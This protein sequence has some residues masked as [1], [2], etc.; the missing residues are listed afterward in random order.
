MADSGFDLGFGGDPVEFAAS[1]LVGAAE[2]LGELLS[3]SVRG[4]EASTKAGRDAL[5]QVF[6]SPIAGLRSEVDDVRVEVSPIT[7]LAEPEDS[8]PPPPGPDPCDA[9]DGSV[10]IDGISRVDHSVEGC[11]TPLGE[12]PTDDPTDPDRPTQDPDSPEPPSDPPTDD[13][14]NCCCCP[15]KCDDDDPEPPDEPEDDDK[16]CLWVKAETCEYVVLSVDQGDTPPDLGFVRKSCCPTFDECSDRGEEWKRRCEK[17]EPPTVPT[18]GGAEADD[19]CNP[20]LVDNSSA[21]LAN[22][23]KSLGLDRDVNV[24]KVLKEGGGSWFRSIASLLGIR[25]P[26]G[27]NYDPVDSFINDLIGRVFGAT[28]AAKATFGCES[29]EYSRITALNSIFSLIQKYTITLPAKIQAEMSYAENYLCPWNLPTTD[30][31]D[32]AL[33]GNTITE[34]TH[35]NL[36]K[37]NGDCPDLH[38]AVLDAKRRKLSPL[39]SVALARRGFWSA[40][41]AEDEIRAQGFVRP[42]SGAAFDEL[43]RFLAS[44]SD[45]I[46]LMQRDVFDE[47]TV[48]RFQLDGIES[49]GSAFEQKYTGAAARRGDAVGLDSETARLFWRAHWELPSEIRLREFL[50][51]FREI[52]DGDIPERAK[53]AG[54]RSIPANS[55][56]TDPRL[57]ISVEDVRQALI[58]DDKAPGW[59]EQYVESSYQPLTRVDVR[60]AYRL[61]VLTIDDVFESLLQDGYSLDNAAILTDFAKEEKNLSITDAEPYKLYRDGLLTFDEAESELTARGF[62]EERIFEQLTRAKRIKIRQARQLDSYRLYVVG[63]GDESELRIDL[64]E[65]FYDPAEI[66]DIVERANRQIESTHRRTCES[67]IK[68]RYFRGDIDATE[69]KTEL[70]NIGYNPFYSQSRVD[71]WTCERN[72]TER[73]PALRQLAELYDLGLINE[74]DLGRRLRN[75]RYANDDISRI[76]AQINIRQ[77]IN[78]D[79]ASAKAQRDEQRAIEKRQAAAERDRRRAEAAAERER[80]TLARLK[81]ERERN[82]LALAKAAEKLAKARAISLAEA[83]D[84]LQSQLG[85][86]VADWSFDDKTAISVIVRAAE[87]ISGDESSA[88]ADIVDLIAADTQETI[89][90]LN[91]SD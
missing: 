78:R 64:L 3:Q 40:S 33:L 12:P 68:T 10:W 84:R 14:A 42:D 52:S 76:V 91:G 49:Q 87:W 21:I 17:E 9:P 67:G 20:A 32:A 37:F 47:S 41:R 79:R 53:N 28:D 55:P 85:R 15:C 58:Q 66:N 48:E 74:D 90:A 22:I 72:A 11:L 27:I 60:R 30:Q 89:D 86:V 83:T 23:Q 24:D 75:L 61:G 63:E 4:V 38:R 36:V 25:L 8:S 13:C 73:I 77:Q 5:S 34:S 81:T 44:P 29:S 65:R 31:A 50:A 26:A 6:D 57:S 35:T 62:D 54:V 1:E 16:Y 51:R 45:L 88:L 56:R 43:F 7:M 71:S 82:A 46:R 39:D 69:A 2:T 59:I 18:F 80:K 70:E 19:F